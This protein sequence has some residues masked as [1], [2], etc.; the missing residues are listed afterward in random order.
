VTRVTGDATLD[1]SRAARQT[2]IP[3][4]LVR[5]SKWVR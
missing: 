4:N 5:R 3:A 2:G 1:R